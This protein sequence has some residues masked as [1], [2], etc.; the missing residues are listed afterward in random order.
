MTFALFRKKNEVVLWEI[1]RLDGITIYESNK[2]Y[3][4]SI[5]HLLNKLCCINKKALL[6]QSDFK[7]HFLI[8]AIDCVLVVC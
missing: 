8:F 2:Q 4:G 1:F 5:K 7:I 3:L 6:F